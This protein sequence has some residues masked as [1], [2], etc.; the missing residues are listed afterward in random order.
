MV[1]DERMLRDS[2]LRDRQEQQGEQRLG[3]GALK[4]EEMRYEG[5]PNVLHRWFQHC[6]P[7]P[8]PLASSLTECEEITGRGEADDVLAAHAYYI[9]LGAHHIMQDRT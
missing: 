3:L 7:T 8:A 9:L 1:D 5:A 2:F 6:P 4:R